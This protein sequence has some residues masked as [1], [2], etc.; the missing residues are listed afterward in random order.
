M[1]TQQSRDRHRLA[2]VQTR[3]TEVRRDQA[4]RLARAADVMTSQHY[5]DEA[6]PEA[7]RALC[8]VLGQVR[9]AGE[10]L[11]RYLDEYA[12]LREQVA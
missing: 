12:Q 3:L 8:E 7:S 9:Q 4:E 1:I 10:V 2:F 5:R 6:N 11:D